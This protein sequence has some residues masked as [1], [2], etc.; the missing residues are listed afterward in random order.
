MS[1]FLTSFPNLLNHHVFAATTLD[2]NNA[3]IQDAFDQVATPFDFGAGHIQPNFAM[4]PGLVYDL[5]TSDYLNLFCATNYDKGLIKMFNNG[6]SYTC[7]KSYRM[8]DFNYPSITVANIGAEPKTVSRRVT[9]VG[10]PG[11]YFVETHV[12]K[13][14]TISVQP[15]SLTFTNTGETKSFQVI[16]GVKGAPQRGEYLFGELRWSYGKYKV[17]SPIVVQH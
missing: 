11:T 16:L 10:P 2:N 5:D 1:Y 6:T 12:P 15:K 8:E 13:E 14:L 3:P 4:D 17:R 7:P 9:N